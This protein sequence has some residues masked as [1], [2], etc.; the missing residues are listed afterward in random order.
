MIPADIETAGLPIFTGTFG[1]A[2]PEHAAW[3][4][5]RVLQYL[6]EGWDHVVTPTEVGDCA[7]ACPDVTKAVS[8]PYYGLGRG[9]AALVEDGHLEIVGDVSKGGRRVTP[10]FVAVLE[11]ARAR[12][13]KAG[14]AS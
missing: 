4:V 3:L 7:K 9:L 12:V 5:V 10:S 13:L 2:E 6:G 8:N 1:K 14:G 11:E